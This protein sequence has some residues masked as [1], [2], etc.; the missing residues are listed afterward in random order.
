MDSPLWD[1]NSKADPTMYYTPE[2][3]S[4]C[5]AIRQQL[6]NYGRGIDRRDRELLL[7]VWHEDATVDYSVPGVTTPGE[8]IELIFGADDGSEVWLHP[9]NAISIK[10]QGSRAV[11]E[12]YVTAK[13]IRRLTKTTVKETLIEARYFDV[14]SQRDGR[15]A[16]DSRKAITDFRIDRE[17]EG[18]I[19]MTQGRPD[20]TDPSYAIFAA[21]DTA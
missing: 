9:L 18:T 1:T 14:W 15:W 6:A 13:A 5:E 8:L 4:A 19:R 11:S 10:V 20:R 21:L 12:A 3:L 17:I 2:A 16:I 7:A